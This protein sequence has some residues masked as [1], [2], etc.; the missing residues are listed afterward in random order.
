MKIILITISLFLAACGDT[1]DLNKAE[2]YKYNY[3]SN[4][5]K[6][7][8]K[9]FSSKE[10]YCEGLKNDESNNNCAKDIRYEKFQAECPGKNW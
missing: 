2:S 6:T 10:D 5:C 1:K 9:S 4:G 3:E 7:G 8:E